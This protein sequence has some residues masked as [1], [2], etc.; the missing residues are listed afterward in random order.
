MSDHA[1]SKE[2]CKDFA[3]ALKV[4]DVFN[5]K[6]MYVNVIT[7]K[8]N[9]SEDQNCITSMFQATFYNLCLVMLRY[10]LCV[11]FMTAM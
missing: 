11:C 2:C 10:V 5:K 1:G 9:A 6:Q 7:G 3:F 8:E 4:F